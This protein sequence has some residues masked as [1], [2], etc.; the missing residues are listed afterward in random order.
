MKGNLFRR[1]IGRDEKYV[2]EIPTLKDNRSL[3]H[4]LMVVIPKKALLVD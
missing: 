2:Y 3:P 1:K 4:C